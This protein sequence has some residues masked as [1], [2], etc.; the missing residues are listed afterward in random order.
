MRP[1]CRLCA[2]PNPAP[3]PQLACCFWQLPLTPTRPH[4]TPHPSQAPTWTPWCRRWRRSGL[5]AWA[6]RWQTSTSGEPGPRPCAPTAHADLV[7]PSSR[8]SCC[9]RPRKY[10]LMPLNP[11]VLTSQTLVIRPLHSPTVQYRHFEIQ[12]AGVPVSHPHPRALL[13]GHPVGSGRLACSCW[14][15]CSGWLGSDW[16]ACDC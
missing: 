2:C 11:L 12:R 8:P 13:P 15:A 4:T 14:L 6:S 9:L 7:C 16:S 5:I 1:P 3:R 10:P